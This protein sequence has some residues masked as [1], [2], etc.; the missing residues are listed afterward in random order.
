MAS[1]NWKTIS[2]VS[3]RAISED[4]QQALAAREVAAR[5][6][7]EAD[8]AGLP[9]YV[10]Q[11]SPNLSARA[12]RVIAEMDPGELCPPCRIFGAQ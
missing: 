1:N 12:D 8:Q 5:I 10:V 11:V 6:T 4:I 2:V 3:D 7:R 9:T